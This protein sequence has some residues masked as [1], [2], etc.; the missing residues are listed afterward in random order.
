M[1]DKTECPDC[2][3][4]F[5]DVFSHI[6]KQ[7]PGRVAAKAPTPVAASVAGPILTSHNNPGPDSPPPSYV[8]ATS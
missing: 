8:P 5:I 3:R 4:S 7:H 2:G 1:P 6:N